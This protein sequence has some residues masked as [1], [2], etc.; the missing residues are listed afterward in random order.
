MSKTY[1][2]NKNLLTYLTNFLDANDLLKLSS[3]NKPLNGLLN[4][5]NNDAV[6]KAYYNHVTKTFFE[7]EEDFEFDKPYREKRN[8]YLDMYW[9]NTINWKSYFI[10]FKKDIKYFQDK[11]KKITK[12]ILD[13]LR[14]HLYLQDLRKENYHLEFSNSSLY[15][16]FSYDKKF[17]EICNNT[18]Y[19]KYINKDY[20]NKEGKDCEIKLLRNNLFFEEELKNFYGQYK[21]INS[22]HD[23]KIILEAINSYDFQK[24]DNFYEKVNKNGSEINTIINFILWINK[25]FISY[26]MYILNS[27]NIFEDDATGRMY[28]EEYIDKY[29]NFVNSILLVNANFQ[30]VNIIINFLNYFILHK[31]DS[32]FSLE[33]LGMKI[34]KKT[35]YD[36][37]ADKIYQK[38]SLLYNKLLINKLENKNE[39]KME[40]EDNETN[41][42]SLQDISLDDSYSDFPKEKTDKEILENL[43]KCILDFSM[44]KNNINA[45][46]HS[47]IKLDDSYEIYENSLIN[48][49][50]EIIEQK[51]GK[52]MQISEIFEILKK[53]LEN[54][55]NSRKTLIKNSNSLV[56]INK[57]KKN[58]LENSFQLLFKN[59]LGK[60]NEDINSRLKPHMDGR[61][62]TIS[63]IEKINNK[64]Y[65]CD[66]SD[67]S[68]K[69]KMKIE[70]K[71]EDELNNVKTFLYEQ[72][73]KGFGIDETNSLINEYIG[74]NGIE[75]V[76]LMKKIIYF[77]YKECEYYDEKDQ[78]VYDILTNKGTNDTEKSS[79]AKIITL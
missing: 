28:L 2:G 33:E 53:L 17:R 12:K 9:K 62:I 32:H 71:V 49:T 38:T 13:I 3:S 16:T 75:L 44:N 64:D 8:N 74:N 68:Q 18:Y 27:V 54:D 63:N 72:N 4:P 58:I 36:K 73:I 47:C 70:K 24:L 39:D 42:T 57:T 10:Q 67:F 55:G 52:D 37:L 20:I 35:V 15:Q 60:L 46:N 30:N 69:K 65:S 25:I 66:L 76:L 22:C 43:L 7:M 19:S 41:D 6:N 45:I 79:F 31:N 26:C 77:Y 14:I 51:L 21:A 40:I 48:S 5:L 34:F 56:L 11:D 78:K 61:T 23:Y 59:L 29:T 1:F 50:K